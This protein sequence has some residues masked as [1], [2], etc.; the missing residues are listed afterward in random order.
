MRRSR[1]VLWSGERTNGIAAF[2]VLEATGNLLKLDPAS[3]AVMATA[4]VGLN[5][6]HVSVGADSARLLVTRFIT[7]A[8]P[9]EGTARVQTEVAGTKRGGVLIHQ[10]GLARRAHDPSVGISTLPCSRLSG[11]A[12]QRQPR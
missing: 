2:V 12:A 6:R 8:L 3:G 1:G 5:A 7:P 11:E 4:A 9:G 10:A